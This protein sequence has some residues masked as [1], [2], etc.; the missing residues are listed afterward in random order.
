MREMTEEFVP[1]DV[2][3]GPAPSGSGDFQLHDRDVTVGLMA[4]Q[5]PGRRVL[6]VDDNHLI[7]RL[8]ALILESAGYAPVEAESAE[9]ALAIAVDTP[10]DAWIVD[11]VMPGLSGSELVRSLRHSRDA[12][13]SRAP[14]VGISGRA[15]AS[16]DLLAAGCDAFVAKPI[17]ERRVLAALRR[18]AR[19]RDPPERRLALA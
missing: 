5:G 8:L 10:P 2:Q 12:R 19:L 17:D 9:D 16:V 1:R 3:P 13:V 18:A 4:G 11:E 14:I 7:R 15:G 6:V